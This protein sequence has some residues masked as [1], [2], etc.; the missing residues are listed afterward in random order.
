MNNGTIPNNSIAL[1]EKYYFINTTY[2]IILTLYSIY[3]IKD[4][5][6]LELNC[7]IIR[8]HL[9]LFLLTFTVLPET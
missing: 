8:L 7:Q 2:K 1:F 5:F 4:K 3:S 6:V 9:T